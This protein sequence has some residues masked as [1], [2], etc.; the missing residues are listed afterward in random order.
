MKKS[1]LIFFCILFI[2]TT[3]AQRHRGNGEIKW[4]SLALKGGYGGTVMF[5]NDVSADK[6]VTTNFL[7]SSYS[8]GGR[9]G[10]TYGDHFSLNFEPSFSGF[11]QEYNIKDAAGTY[12]KHQKFTS[13][14]YLASLRYVTNYGF[15]FEAGPQFSTL[16]TASVENSKEGLFNE[17]N[18]N[19]ISNFIEKYTNLV[20]GMGYAIHNGDRLQLFLGLRGTYALGDF[21]PDYYV[22]SDGVYNPTGTFISPTNPFTLKLMV[23]VNY[24]FGFWGDANCGKGRLVF[25]Q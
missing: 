2:T 12:A 15:Y 17:Y 8:Y 16:K 10:F 14:D 19:Y 11:G 13:L 1:T 9:F 25:F 4:L 20:A 7:S 5:N 21:D 3:F 24:F 6:N 22:L 23:E 18:G